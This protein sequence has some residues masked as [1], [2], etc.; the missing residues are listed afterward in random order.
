LSDNNTN[1][2]S[3]RLDQVAASR[4]DLHSTS[5]AAINKNRAELMDS[6]EKLHIS[7]AV[8]QDNI[9]AQQNQLLSPLAKETI[10]TVYKQGGRSKTVVMHIGQRVEEFGAMIAETQGKLKS[11]WA[12][13]EVVQRK[14]IELGVDVL[15]SKAF[16]SEV[17]NVQK[18]LKGYRKEMEMLDA[19]DEAFKE[20]IEEELQLLG[21]EAMSKM[22]AT[23]KVNSRRY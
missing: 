16:P 12:D 2:Y 15:G 5:I 17:G 4:T 21:H 19:E 9:S 13:W 11:C 22:K 8:F 1:V 3:A 18:E 6:L 14:I 23:E 20:E 10:Q 7:G